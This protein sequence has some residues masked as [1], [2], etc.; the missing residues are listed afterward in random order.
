MSEMIA[1]FLSA[2]ALTSIAFAANA[3]IIT[4]NGPTSDY[5]D[6]QTAQ[7]LILNVASHGNVT[8]LTVHLDVAAP[9][10]DD[11][12]FQLLHNGV[13]VQ[14]YNGV[15]DTGS[16]FFNV[17]FKDGAAAAP[18]NGSMVGTFR[19]VDSLSAFNG[20]DVF[21]AWTLR[22]YDIV[23]PGDQNALTGWS[24]TATTAAAVPEPASLGLLGA[25][26]FGMGIARRRKA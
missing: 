15:G 19:A 14:L 11:V 24:I 4:V 5:I 21:G 17:T 22:A 10:A 2:L 13:L 1:K 8:G 12:S 7:D 26:L 20:L 23:V 6:T 16:S 25:A 9:Y 3:G 18:F